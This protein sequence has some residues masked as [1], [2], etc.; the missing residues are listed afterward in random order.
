MITD[1]GRRLHERPQEERSAPIQEHLDEPAPQDTAA[2]EVPNPRR[3]AAGQGTSLTGT[4]VQ[5]VA[6]SRLVL[7]LTGSGT[8]V[9]PA[10][11]V[12]ASS[13]RVSRTSAGPRSSPCPCS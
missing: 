12:P 4:W 2:L 1:E 9:G 13:G 10:V 8:A 11:R 7:E 3:Y 6:Q 5:R